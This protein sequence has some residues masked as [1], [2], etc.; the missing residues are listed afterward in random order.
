MKLIQIIFAVLV[1]IYAASA[2][3][4]ITEI[5]Y[6]PTQGS[7]TDLEWI[8]IYNNGNAPVDLASWTFDGSNFDDITINPKEYIVIARELIDGTDE[9]I[10]SFAAFYG[11][12]DGIW[13]SNDGFR[14]VDGSM[15]LTNDNFLV[16][17]SGSYTDSVNYSNSWGGNGNG[18]SIYKIDYSLPNTKEN[19]AESIFDFGTPGKNKNNNGILVT[20]QV[21]GSSTEITSID[22][23]D[24]SS[25]NGYQILPIANEIKV[26]PI[27]VDVSTQS[28]VTAYAELNN[29]KITLT[30]TSSNS[31][32]K[33]FSGN[34]QMPFYN[35]QG[36]YVVN[37]SVTDQ[38]QKTTSQLVNF[39]YLP[40]IS[41]TFDIEEINFGS[42]P[43]GSSSSEK[44]VTVKNTGNVLI[45]LTASATDLKNGFDLIP[46]SSLQVKHSSIYLPLSTTP[47]NLDI[48]LL[49]GQSSNKQIYFKAD[50]PQDVNPNIYSGVISLNA[51]EG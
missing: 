5:M 24:D 19:W 44:T 29:N 22:L 13:E 42:L 2:N 6:N 26:I 41:S 36:N 38:S 35:Q 8:E 1:S 43:S 7:D 12:N 45:D 10:E 37:V 33:S 25:N 9:D 34:L 28:T 18:K 16:L 32:S 11:N 23:P 27:T 31:T 51:V 4:V 46:A 15:S 40:L 39:E 48:N 14:A 20:L 30:Q 3:V 49:P 17:S 47:T 21:I 50:V